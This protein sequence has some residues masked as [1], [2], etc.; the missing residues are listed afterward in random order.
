MRYHQLFTKFVSFG[1][2]IRKNKKTFV[3]FDEL[4]QPTLLLCIVDEGE[5]KLAQ[6]RGVF[7]SFGIS[8]L[9]LLGSN[10]VLSPGTAVVG[11][12]QQKRLYPVEDPGKPCLR[13]FLGLKF[14]PESGEFLPLI[15]GAAFSSR[16]AVVLL[17][18]SS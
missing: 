12:V 3:D 6:S 13:S 18:S 1:N 15:L 16:S 2:S 4:F 9:D 14:T 10:T 8:V 5:D 11:V 7:H 17:P